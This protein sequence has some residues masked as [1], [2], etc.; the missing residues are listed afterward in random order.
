MVD[1]AQQGPEERRLP[2]AV[3]PDEADPAPL[4]DG[5]GQVIEQDLVPER[6]AEILN[7]DQ[8]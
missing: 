4:G 8:G 7:A 2:R 3:V 5:P 1:L 6:Q